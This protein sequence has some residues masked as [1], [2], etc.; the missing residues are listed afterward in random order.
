M[1][2]K[3]TNNEESQTILKVFSG[4]PTLNC[5][6]TMSIPLVGRGV[7]KRD[8]LGNVFSKTSS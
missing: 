7:D 1:K 2:R 3:S 8:E 5:D 4:E 6:P